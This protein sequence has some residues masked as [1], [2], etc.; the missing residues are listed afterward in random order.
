MANNPRNSCI[1][2]ESGAWRR[3]SLNTS[4]W[5]EAVPRC[6]EVTKMIELRQIREED[7]R[8]LPTL[9]TQYRNTVRA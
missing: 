6:F 4:P 7:A 3:L 9:P 8:V 1:K 5:C 2:V